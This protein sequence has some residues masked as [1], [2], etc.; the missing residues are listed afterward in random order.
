MKTLVYF[1]LNFI[2]SF[3]TYSYIL[4]LLYILAT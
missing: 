4:T 2:E 1:A 3:Y